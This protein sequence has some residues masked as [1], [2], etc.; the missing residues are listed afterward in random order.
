[1]CVQ[2]DDNVYQAR[3]NAHKAIEMCVHMSPGTEG[4]VEAKL[5][6]VLVKTLLEEKDEIKV[7]TLE[8]T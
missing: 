6:P 8:G 7:S 1:M 3:L 4:V 2:F 5:I